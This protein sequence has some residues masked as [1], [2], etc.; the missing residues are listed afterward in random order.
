MN[1]ETEIDKMTIPDEK[2]F[3]TKNQF[4]KCKAVEYS[5]SG[6]IDLED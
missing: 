2:N 4:N 5:D 6:T 1:N 3:V